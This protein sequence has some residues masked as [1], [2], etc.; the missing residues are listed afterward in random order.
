MRFHNTCGQTF[1]CVM[2]IIIRDVRD[3]NVLS[4]V[5]LVRSLVELSENVYTVAR[6]WA[7]MRY[8]SGLRS[9]SGSDVPSQFSSERVGSL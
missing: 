1:L 2:E 9:S 7:R 4:F 5:C 8:L 3:C 6:N